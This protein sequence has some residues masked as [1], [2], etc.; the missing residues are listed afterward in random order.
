MKT[1]SELNVQFPPI[2]FLGLPI[3]RKYM[4][5]LRHGL[6]SQIVDTSCVSD[7]RNYL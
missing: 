1:V 4:H 2:V 5:I 6:H 7:I 3:K